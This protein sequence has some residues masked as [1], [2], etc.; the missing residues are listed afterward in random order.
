MGD[1]STHNTGAPSL[2]EMVDRLDALS[3]QLHRTRLA[4]S[5]LSTDID[6][7][8]DHVHIAQRDISL[9]DKRLVTVERAVDR[10]EEI[11]SPLHNVITFYRR[12]SVVVT[13]LQLVTLIVALVYALVIN[14]GM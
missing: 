13:T 6:L 3:D 4:V 10:V 9:A 11:I 2:S 1:N 5:A 7:L 14:T 8:Y 12:T